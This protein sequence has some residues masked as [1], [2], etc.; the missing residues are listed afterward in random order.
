MNDLSIVIPVKSGDQAWR[1]L[2]ADLSAFS[3]DFE[4]ILV[5]PD[6]IE[7][8]S[9]DPRIKYV[10]CKQGRAL[11]LNHGA[12]V[13]T[14]ANIW[15]LHAD[16][17]LS[18]RSIQKVEENLKASPDAIFFFDLNFLPDGPRIMFL[19]AIGA[20]WRSHLLKMPFGDQGFFM[21]RKTFFALGMFNENAKYGEDHLFI[22]RAH[23]RGVDVL[24]AYAE[25][26][27][28]ARKYKNIGWVTTTTRHVFLTYKQAFPEWIKLI[29]TRNKKKWTSAIAIFVKTPEVS[30]IKTRL[31]AT[32][33]EQNAIEFYE[34]SLKATQA[35]VMEAIKKSD[36]K[37]EAY[38]AVAEKDQLDNSHWNSFKTISQGTGDLGDRLATVYS[39]LQQKHRKVFLIGA[40][41]PQ[42]N[43]KTLL[44][45]EFKLI[46][47]SN[48]ILGETIDGGF[49]LFGAR[50]IIERANW[51]AI[52]YSSDETAAMLVQ[53]FGKS[54]AIFLDKMFDIDYVEDLWNL[55]EY[56]T[57]ELLPEQIAIIEWSKKFR[58]T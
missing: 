11:Q 40:D 5:G 2:L 4:V 37:L 28:S 51:K 13:A 15:F 20:Y 55:G 33:G 52:P 14:K 56:A 32:I 17:R 19:N 8:K 10:Y 57:E 6:F 42:I 43:Y 21:R 26:F 35:V 45:A 49:Y 1:E 23:Q 31:A 36:G 27:T 47:S 54:Q 41:S 24:P 29:Q 53:K 30:E 18:N 38:W 16:S 9:E 12:S 34:L 58:P 48:Y 22:W 3:A 46:S 25:L 39:K 7:F 50:G 44:K